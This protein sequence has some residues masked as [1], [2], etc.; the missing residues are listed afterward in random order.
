MTSSRAACSGGVMPVDMFARFRGMAA[1]LA[2][3]ASRAH[4]AVRR[5]GWAYRQRTAYPAI[6]RDEKL[7]HCFDHFRFR[8]AGNRVE[9]VLVL[10]CLMLHLLQRV[11]QRLF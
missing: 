5:Y 1:I 7:L 2:V 8:V 3:P 4:M 11:V 10:N 9:A 6:S